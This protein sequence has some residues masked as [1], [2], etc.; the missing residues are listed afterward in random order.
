MDRTRGATRVARRRLLACVVP[1][2]SLEAFGLFGPLPGLDDVAFDKE[3]LLKRDPPFRTT[4]GEEL[5]VHREMLELFLLSVLHDRPRLFVGLDR[6]A[7]GVPADCYRLFRQ[8]GDHSGERP[9][10]GTELAR[11]LVVL[12]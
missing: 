2:T 8:R 11:G 5:E 12:V 4:T 6:D 9:G 1:R 3:G 7:L 10:L